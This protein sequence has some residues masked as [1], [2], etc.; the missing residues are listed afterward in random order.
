MDETHHLSNPKN[1]LKK[2][3]WVTS[4]T[5]IFF[6]FKNEINS[7]QIKQKISQNSSTLTQQKQQIA[8]EHRNNHRGYSKQEH[9]TNSK[10]LQNTQTITLLH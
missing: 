1:S 10:T 2:I 5:S 9:N 8:T 3:F 6:Y 4:R 7:R